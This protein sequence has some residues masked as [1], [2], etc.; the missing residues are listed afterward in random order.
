[1]DRLHGAPEA[2]SY[3]RFQLFNAPAAAFDEAFLHQN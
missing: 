2:L 3:I 1:M